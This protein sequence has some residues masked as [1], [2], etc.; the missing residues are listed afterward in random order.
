[1]SACHHF[2]YGDRRDILKLKPNFKFE[3]SF[4]A[5]LRYGYF[6]SIFK[7]KQKSAILQYGCQ[8]ANFKN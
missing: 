7:L 5:I 2:N 4:S 1:M 8:R 6:R 3:W